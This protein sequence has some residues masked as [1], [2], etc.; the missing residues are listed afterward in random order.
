[1]PQVMDLDLGVLKRE[2]KEQRTTSQTVKKYIDKK[3]K[4]RFVGTSEL[5]KSHKL[6]PHC[7][8]FA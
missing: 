3:G 1:M 6:G 5:S 8:S 7:F 4:V 2:E